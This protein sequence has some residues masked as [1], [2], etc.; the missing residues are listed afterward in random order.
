MPTRYGR[1]HVNACGPQEAQPLLLLPGQAI[2]STMWY[3]N[4]GALSRAHRLLALDIIGDLGKSVSSRPRLSPQDYRAWLIE[5][6]DGLRLERAHVAGLSFG[7][8]L[9]LRLALSAP[10]RVGKLVLMAPAGQLPL[11]RVFFLRMGVVLL[12]AFVMSLEVKQKWLLGTYSPNLL[13]AFQQMMTSA[14]FR[15][16]IFLSPV[17]TGKELAQVQPST[18]LLVGG[19]E[20]VYDR[21]AASSRA[22]NMIPQIEIEVIPGAGHALNFDRPEMVNG[23][24]LDFLKEDPGWLHGLGQ[25]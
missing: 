25:A 14:D 23:Y 8:Y 6:M 11:R 12:P 9:A 21:Q 10:E 5:V 20:V 13:P 22:A 24:L 15:Y 19:H 3:P 17:Y 16:Q 18:L 1:T 7:G 2:S 4:V